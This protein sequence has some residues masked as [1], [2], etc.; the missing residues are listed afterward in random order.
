MFLS[1]Y[2]PS[3]NIRLRSEKNFHTRFFRHVALRNTGCNLHEWLAKRVGWMSIF[4]DYGF[5]YQ[6]F[7]C[8]DSA[9]NFN[10]VWALVSRLAF[11]V[12]ICRWLKKH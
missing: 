9:I 3:A 12:P 6:F 5:P 10:V 8:P 11:S 1:F 4:R 7:S 2:K